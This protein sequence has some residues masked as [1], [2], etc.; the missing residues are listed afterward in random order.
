[1]AVNRFPLWCKNGQYLSSGIPLFPSVN[2][3]QA[4]IFLRSRTSPYS[5]SYQQFV[6]LCYGREPGTK[7]FCPGAVLED[8]RPDVIDGPPVREA[9]LVFRYIENQVPTLKLYQGLT[10]LM[11]TL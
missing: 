7:S 6:I 10:T 4:G 11:F 2:N 1:M 8:R 3:S 5:R 9:I